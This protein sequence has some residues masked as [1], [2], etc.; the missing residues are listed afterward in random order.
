MLWNHDA[1][2]ETK[3]IVEPDSEGRVKLGRESRATEIWST[4]SQAHHNRDFRFNSQPLGVAFTERASIGGRSWPNV[5]FIKPAQ[6]MAYSLWGNSTLGLICYWYHSSRQ[7]AGRGS[8]PITALRTMPTLDVTKLSDDQLNTAQ[9]IFEDMKERT[10]LPANEAWRDCSR[11]ELDRR[12]L[13]DLLELPES[14]LEPLELLR[15]KW[16][17][18]PSVHGGKSTAP[19]GREG[20]VV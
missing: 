6:E 19:P 15:L 10:F 5:K 7:H 1:E 3:L 12:V 18:E 2:L 13:V 11:N 9:A 14:V 20:G 8:I 17:S 4:R 16:C